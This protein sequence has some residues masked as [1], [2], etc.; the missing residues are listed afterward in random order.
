MKKT[1]KILF[2]VVA[3]LAGV[4]YAGQ[5]L[6]LWSL[7]LTFD[8]WWTLFLIIPAISNMIASRV[9]VGNSVL[10]GLGLWLLIQEQGIFDDIKFRKVSFAIVLVVIGIALIVSELRHRKIVTNGD[11]ESVVKSGDSTKSRQNSDDNPSYFTAFGSETIINNSG[12]LVGGEA[13]ALFGGLEIDLSNTIPCG[14]VEFDAKSIFGGIEIIP[15]E[16]FH[17]VTDGFSLFGGCSNKSKNNTGE[18]L[19]IF[20]IRYFTLFG[21]IDIL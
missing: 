7:N 12:S 8:G 13:T 19:P 16:G 17:V 3:V 18:S 4:I 2:G 10:L 11:G 14:N 6:E 15:P 9:N 5:A 1:S 20:T 21:G